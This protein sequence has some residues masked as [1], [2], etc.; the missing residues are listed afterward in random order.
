MLINKTLKLFYILV[1]C[2]K[3]SYGGTNPLT[4][5]TELKIKVFCIIT[6]LKNEESGLF[7]LSDFSSNTSSLRVFPTV[8]L[9]L[10]IYIY[11]SLL[12]FH[13]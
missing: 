2:I 3:S 11:T 6:I 10:Y 4:S 7:V 13:R 1:N 5:N 8:I 9:P 12:H